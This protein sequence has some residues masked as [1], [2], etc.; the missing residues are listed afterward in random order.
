MQLSC[1]VCKTGDE[2]CADAFAFGFWIRYAANLIE[3][4]F[5]CIA[6]D[7][8]NGKLFREHLPHRVGFSFAHEAVIDVYAGQPA[9][10]R[11]ADERSGDGG[12]HTAGEAE[13]HTTVF[14]D[15][16]ADGGNGQFDDSVHCPVACAAAD[17]VQE[18]LKQQTA[19][20][21][22]RDLRMELH[23]VDLFIRIRHCAEGTIVAG[24]D[25]RKAFWSLRDMVGM[26]HPH[27]GLRLHAGT[28][29]DGSIKT[30]FDTAIF[31]VFCPLN[32]A[33]KRMRSQLHAIADAKHRKPQ[34][35]EHGI[36]AR[37]IAVC[38]AGRA[39]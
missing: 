22:V 25:G 12:I 7:E 27:D 6:D 35:V 15:L 13:H 37:R 4:A 34:L 24:G 19:L 16:R 20:L 28:Q 30:D 39:A 2:F 26:A 32:H 8:V 33:A 3:E 11:A 38:D 29:R 14:A 17:A 1:L 18:V 31:S 23:S 5:F 36:D 10:D 21:A 9:A